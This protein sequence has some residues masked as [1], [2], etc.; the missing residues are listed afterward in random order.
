M[1]FFRPANPIFSGKPGQMC[2]SESD[3]DVFS[4]CDGRRMTKWMDQMEPEE[5]SEC[6]FCRNRSQTVI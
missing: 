6:V 2:A 1:N 4:M 3:L 5:M